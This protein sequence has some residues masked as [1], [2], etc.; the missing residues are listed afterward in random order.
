MVETASAGGGGER[1]DVVSSCSVTQSHVSEFTRVE[2]DANKFYTV[3][4]STNCR[5]S[6]GHLCDRLIQG[7]RCT[8]YCIIDSIVNR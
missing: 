4:K 8:F 6:T 7:E 3:N 5:D 1:K 2:I